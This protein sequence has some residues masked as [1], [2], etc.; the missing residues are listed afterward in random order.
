[1]SEHGHAPVLPAPEFFDRSSTGVLSLWLIGAGALGLI[2]SLI[3]A[4]VSW[5]QFAFSWLVA[6]AF[7]F[8]LC[9]GSLFWV[10]VHHATDAEWSVVVRRQL[11]HLATLMPVMALFFVPVLLCAPVLF[12]WW[13]LSPGADPVLDAKAAYLN[14][15]FFIVRAVLYFVLLAGAAYLLRRASV[16]Q[17][18]DGSPEHTLWMR[19]VAIA[20]IPAFG[21]ALTFGAVDW[22]KGLDYKWFSTMWGVYIFAGAAGSAMSLLVLVITG[23]RQAG[24]LKRVVTV[25]H[26][27][28]MGKLMLAFCVFW[29]YIGFSQYMLIW[30]AN[31]PEE[32]SYFLRR[33]TETWQVLSSFL[34]LGR[35]FIPFPILLLQATKKNPAWLCAVAGW[36]VFMQLV[37]IYIIVMPMLHQDGVHFS[38]LDP[39]PL[40][41]IGGTL[42]FLFLRK[43]GTTSLFPTRD[44]RLKESLGLQN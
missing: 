1:M 33:N 41:G 3:G 21:V 18:S 29:A 38:W 39:F 11:E 30:Y 14:V 42:G 36:I 12:G 16:R 40:L 25:E 20:G 7:F 35:F 22:L 32:T 9:A 24:Y 4:L 19:K 15:P 17:D 43:I 13:T 8:T 10:L 44:P 28:I 5:Q 37:D 23:L 2:V 6:F 31:I 26:Y 27:H 34:V